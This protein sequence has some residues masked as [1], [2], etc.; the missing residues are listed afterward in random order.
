MT[1]LAAMDVGTNSVLLA[2][3]EPAADGR[4]QVI[5]DRAVIARLGRGLEPGGRLWPQAA[6]R[7]A[8]VIAELAER[9]RRLG[10][11]DIRAVGTMGLRLAADADAFVARV[12]RDC[13]VA[14]RVISGDE[15]ARLTYRG[16]QHGLPA[17]A[18]RLVVCDVGGGSTEVISG[19]A[20][21]IDGYRSLE[22][23]AVGLSERFLRGDAIGYEQ[24]AALRSHLAARLAGELDAPAQ[25]F[26]LVAVG[27]TATS[28]AAM[29]HRLQRYDAQRVHGTRLSRDWLAKQLM[30]LVRLDEP[31]RA[32]IPGLEPGRADIIP[33]GSAILLG[34]SDRLDAPSLLI[35][36]RGLRHGLLLEAAGDP[37]AAG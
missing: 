22:L 14:I 29:F 27:G 33:A 18:E 16:A 34:L 15:E 13:G 1:R 12:E 7:T 25:P 24:L 10:A 37:P 31:A 9:A 35:S 23:G 2:V 4:L 8:A 32:R 5:E 36:D 21:R 26:E 28:L 19:R 17:A 30:E 3:A 20:A 6:D 11:A